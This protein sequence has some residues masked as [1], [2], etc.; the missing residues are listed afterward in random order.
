MGKRCSNVTVSKSVRNADP[1]VFRVV[2][3]VPF[4]CVRKLRADPSGRAV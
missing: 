2:T 4:V 1:F 3:A